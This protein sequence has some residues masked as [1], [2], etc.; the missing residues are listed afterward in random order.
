MVRGFSQDR[1]PQ[2]LLRTEFEELLPQFAPDSRHVAFQSDEQGRWEVF[3]MRFPDGDEKQQVS[4]N[5]GIHPRWSPRGDELFYLEDSVV[6]AVPVE[7]EPP[8]RL[9][10][11][12]P[13]FD[14]DVIGR[15]LRSG[16]S[17]PDFPNYSVDIGG[18]R[19][20]AVR[21]TPDDGEDDSNCLE[22]QAISR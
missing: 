14:G 19:F 17:R 4:V 7:V 16:Y 2:P 3:V 21:A 20:V 8:L 10:T 6:M 15:Q 12:Q 22:S 13:L 1:V 5:G 18:R 9:G 11:P